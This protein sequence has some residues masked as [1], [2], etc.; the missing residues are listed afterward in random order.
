LIAIRWIKVAWEQVKL[1]VIIN[2]VRH[3][4]TILGGVAEDPFAGIAADTAVLEL[5]SQT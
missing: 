3:S 2:C 4:G 1:S 5:V